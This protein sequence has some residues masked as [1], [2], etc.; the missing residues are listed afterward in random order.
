MMLGI[1]GAGK[2]SIAER[3]AEITKAVHISSDQFRKHMFDNPE[4]ITKIEHDQIYDMLD[5]IAGQILKSGKS[6]IYDANLNQYVH[7]LEKYQIC[8]DVNALPKL[9]WVKTS[10]E[11]ARK[12]ATEQADLHPR[13]RPF[14]NMRTET[15]ERLAAQMEEPKKDEKATVISG[16][17]INKTKIKTVIKSLV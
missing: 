12:R 4:N 8:K 11:V 1:P 7:R 13:H 14:G 15:F 5:Y 17:E 6:V 3:I 9:V 16:D 10:E 2:T